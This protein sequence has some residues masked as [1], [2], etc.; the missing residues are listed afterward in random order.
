MCVSS[1]PFPCP[2]PPP[3]SPPQLHPLSRSIGPVLR[4][5]PS[6]LLADRVV[7]ILLPIFSFI[8]GPAFGSLD[9]APTGYP[10]FTLHTIDAC[11]CCSSVKRATTWG[12]STACSSRWSAASAAS[13]GAVIVPIPSSASAS[14][15]WC[16]PTCRTP[17]RQVSKFCVSVS[18]VAAIAKP[19]VASFPSVCVCERGRGGEGRGGC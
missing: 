4:G 1:V 10:G 11:C 16:S 19:A 15:W 8:L 5:L 7:I 9:R 3:L 13:R 12:P 2:P 6:G 17:R 14:W 18:K